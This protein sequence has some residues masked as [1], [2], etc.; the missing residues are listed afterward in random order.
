MTQPRSTVSS[1]APDD[2]DGTGATP[3]SGTPAG[4]GTTATG[5]PITVHLA[6][7]VAARVA[8]T[9]VP[10]P[11]TALVDAVRPLGFVGTALDSAPLGAPGWVVACTIGSTD[12]TVLRWTRT[13]EGPE[14]VPDLRWED[15][16]TV[17]GEALGG[18]AH[19]DVQVGPHVVLGDRVYPGEDDDWVPRISGLTSREVVVGR[20]VGEDGAALA[21]TAGAA[22]DVASVDGVL[23]VQAS[24]G[25]RSADLLRVAGH[26]ADGPVLL[27]WRNDPW[28]GFTAIRGRRSVTHMWGPE[29]QVID[30]SARF[31]DPVVEDVV[32]TVRPDRATGSQ[33]VALFGLTDDPRREAVRRLVEEESPPRAM[34][35]FLALLGLP[36][37]ADQVLDGTVAVA[38]LKG[39]RT[40]P[41][42]RFWR[43]A[44]HAD[45]VGVTTRRAAIAHGDD[46]VG[47]DVPAQHPGAVHDDTVPHGTPSPA[48]LLGRA[49][50]RWWGRSD[51]G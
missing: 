19:P 42:A 12:G 3:S 33:V 7:H 26:P 48:H 32:T 28:E 20:L 37:V 46:P 30:P 16:G 51:V 18:L 44:R 2:R 8:A 36:A 14:L 43:A 1:H 29:W 22:L 25:S 15:L 23:L 39:A 17:V 27:L 9:D 35:R 41:R 21:R 50:R 47:E 11:L 38:Q 6:V 24:G 40:Y 5:D 34:S 49:G 10:D 45:D 4:S 13:Q 31:G